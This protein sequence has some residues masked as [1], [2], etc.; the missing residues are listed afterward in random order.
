MRSCYEITHLVQQRERIFIGQEF[1]SIL[2]IAERHQTGQLSNADRLLVSSY[3]LFALDFDPHRADILNHL[4]NESLQ[5]LPLLLGSQCQHTY[6]SQSFS[7]HPQSL[8]EFTLRRQFHSPL[9]LLIDR[10]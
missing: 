2:H 4:A 6:A 8:G 5:L 10:G 3:K 1:M 7:E 9:C